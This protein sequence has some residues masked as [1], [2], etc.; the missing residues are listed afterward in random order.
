MMK[1]VLVFWI[2][3]VGTAMIMRD[4]ASSKGRNRLY[5]AYAAEQAEVRRANGLQRQEETEG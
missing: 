1:R 3:V 4:L 2:T 5:R